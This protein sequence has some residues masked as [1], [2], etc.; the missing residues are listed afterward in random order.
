MLIFFVLSGYWIAKTVVHR[1]EKKGFGW[2]DYGIDRLSRLWIVL[3]PA[4][5]LGGILDCVGRYGTEAPIYLGRQGTNALTFDVADRLTLGDFAGNVMFVQTLV[6]NPFGSN[7]PL[8]S[9]ANAFWYY[10]W[11]PAIYELF[12]RRRRF[13]GSR[14]LCSH[15][16]RVSSAAGARFR[17]LA[18]RLDRLLCYTNRLHSRA[19]I[20]VTCCARGGY[21][22]LLRS[23]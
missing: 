22:T 20:Q 23:P 4:L 12:V 13:L 7:G 19:A 5:I 14:F 8:W 15:N 17:L 3:I 6:S 9:L 16:D 10:V 21:V 11:F 18:F 2:T 1:S